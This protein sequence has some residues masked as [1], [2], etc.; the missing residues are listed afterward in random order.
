MASTFKL[1]RS[2][3]TTAN[4]LRKTMHRAAYEGLDRAMTMAADDA[5]NQ[6]RWR[7]AGKHSWSSPR[8][9]WAWTGTG[10]SR[11]SIR[12]YVVGPDRSSRNKLR[13][14]SRPDT[15]NTKNG[16]AFPAQTHR[17][18]PGILP[19]HLAMPGRYRGFLTMY[20]EYVKWLQIKEREGTKSGTPGPGEPVTQA[21]LRNFGAVYAPVIRR[22]I[23]QMMAALKAQ[24]G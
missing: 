11:Q 14:Y 10:L 15:V 24:I 3:K 22:H 2:F 9:T 8:A 18:D 16:R 17:A 13:A 23:Q 21:A 12:G 7:Q 19:A 1:N 6:A 20:P 4:K 5:R